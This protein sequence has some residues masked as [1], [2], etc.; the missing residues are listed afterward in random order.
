MYSLLLIKT[1]VL[2]IFAFPLGHLGTY[3][4]VTIII[5][6]NNVLMFDHF[7]LAWAN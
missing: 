1:A 3:F 5:I 6:G 7:F 4:Q 2:N